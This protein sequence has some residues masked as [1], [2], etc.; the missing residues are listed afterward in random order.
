MRGKDKE[1]TSSGLKELPFSKSG[2]AAVSNGFNAAWL[3]LSLLSAL[4]EGINL[5]SIR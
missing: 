3:L 2:V 5:I 4:N 1:R